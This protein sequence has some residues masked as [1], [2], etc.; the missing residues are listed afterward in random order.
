MLLG[1]T[2]S[3]ITT[4][5]LRRTVDCTVLASASLPCPALLASAPETGTGPTVARA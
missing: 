1:N 4:R 2:R 3:R 5:G